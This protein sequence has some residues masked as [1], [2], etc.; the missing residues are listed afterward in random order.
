MQLNSLKLAAIVEA[1]K[2]KV[3]N[4]A[5]WTV[6]IERAYLHL[7][8]NPYIHFDGDGLLILSDSGKFYHANGTCQCESFKFNKPCWHR[9]CAQLVKRYNEDSSLT[10]RFAERETAVM[11]KPQP[12]GHQIDGWDI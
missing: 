7:L 3:T 8:E 4:N 2:A 5:R 12:R 9:A 11:V 10:Q 1:A 6:A